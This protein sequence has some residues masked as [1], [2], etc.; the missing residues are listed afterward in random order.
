MVAFEFVQRKREDGNGDGDGDDAPFVLPD[1][2]DESEFMSQYMA[3]GEDVRRR[4]GHHFEGRNS[5]LIAYFELKG[6][7]AKC[8]YQG[9]DCRDASLWHPSTAP[10]YGNCFTF[11]AVY[12]DQGDD[13]APRNATLTGATNGLS[14]ELFVDQLN[15]MTGALSERAG[16][17]LIIHNPDS[18]PM[19]D[20][21]GLDVQPGSA[22]SVSI[23]LVGIAE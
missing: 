16:V 20:E 4:I 2:L 14:L 9:A 7:F 6:M 1:R 15:Y 5:S 10:N 13:D 17:R 19:A 22:S 11:N 8:F 21:F 12:N 18:Y 23:H 3:M